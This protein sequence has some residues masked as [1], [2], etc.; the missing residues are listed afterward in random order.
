MHPGLELSIKIGS[1]HATSFRIV[2]NC[3]ERG[4]KGMQ[5]AVRNV[6]FR[7]DV[8]V[9]V[10]MSIRKNPRGHHNLPHLTGRWGHSVTSAGPSGNDW[11]AV[12]GRTRLL[13]SA[14]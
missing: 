13:L 14:L 12:E 1:G 7:C 2:A 6:V 4:K 5:K 10:V 11:G 9:L 3:Q 8:A